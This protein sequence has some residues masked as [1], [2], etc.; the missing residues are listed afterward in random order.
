VLI[1]KGFIAQQFFGIDQ[2]HA[3]IDTVKRPPDGGEKKKFFFLIK[4]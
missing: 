1:D 3:Y 4:Y 2:H